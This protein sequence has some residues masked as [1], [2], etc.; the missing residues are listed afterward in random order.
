MR[1]FRMEQLG[2]GTTPLRYRFRL[3]H[4]AANSGNA[5]MTASTS[6]CPCVP[7]KYI[8]LPQPV[9]FPRASGAFL[10][11][12]KSSAASPFE[13]VA[14]CYYVLTVE[15]IVKELDPDRLSLPALHGGRRH[16]FSPF[17]RNPPR[18]R[19][20]LPLLVTPTFLPSAVVPV[21]GRRYRVRFRPT[22]MT[23]RPTF[24]EL[25]ARIAELERT[26]GRYRRMEEAGIRHRAA[27]GA[28]LE[29]RSRTGR[30]SKPC[31]PKAWI[32]SGGRVESKR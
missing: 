25:K 32:V 11:E 27:A 20:L 10:Q 12:T 4:S 6:G 19:P 8:G 24:D 14:K 3:S 21:A 30:S 18:W 7:S 28:R 2:E 1:R 31:V 5:C 13:P 17:S 22:I 29:A 23:G 15:F 16:K 9:A 26:L